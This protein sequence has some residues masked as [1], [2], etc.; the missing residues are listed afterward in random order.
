MAHAV[1]SEYQ[2]SQDFAEVFAVDGL[3]D[4][5]LVTESVSGLP[6]L[7]GHLEPGTLPCEFR[8]HGLFFPSEEVA[9]SRTLLDDQQRVRMR[10][11]ARPRAAGSAASEAGSSSAEFT[12]GE[13]PT[14]EWGSTADLARVLGVSRDTVDRRLKALEKAGIDLQSLPGAPV[15]AGEGKSRRHRRWNLAQAQDFWRALERALADQQPEAKKARTRHA[16]VRRRRKNRGYGPD[17]DRDLLT[18]VMDSRARKG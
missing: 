12:S 4:V 18:R 7:V 3:V 13:S 14:P 17:D 10:D 11:A 6:F 16:V 1:A 5:E 2:P 8:G 9:R 15:Q